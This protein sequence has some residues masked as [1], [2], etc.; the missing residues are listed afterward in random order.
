MNFMQAL[1][2]HIQASG[3]ADEK[4]FSLNQVM[5]LM[6]RARKLERASIEKEYILVS[7]VT[8]TAKS[9]EPKEGVLL[10][11]LKPRGSGSYKLKD[12]G[13]PSV[14][15]SA[16]EVFS[17]RPIPNKWNPD[18][19]ISKENVENAVVLLLN[20]GQKTATVR[21]IVEAIHDVIPRAFKVGK[22]MIDYRHQVTK[23]FL[24]SEKKLLGRYGSVM[25]KNTYVFTI[26]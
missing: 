18:V 9:E 3:I 17:A 4:M 1:N 14:K 25:D 24:S 5:D 10:K 21:Q 19:A 8:V 20:R 11:I 13:V 15:G 6:A 22:K 26:A 23:R 7:R 16:E 2:A 12:K